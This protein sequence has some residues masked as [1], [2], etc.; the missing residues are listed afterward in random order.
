MYRTEAPTTCCTTLR[1]RHQLQPNLSAATTMSQLGKEKWI[2]LN[3]KKKKEKRISH[4]ISWYHR[5]VGKVA[6]FIA[7]IRQELTW[8]TIYVMLCSSCKNMLRHEV[9]GRC[10]SMYLVACRARKVMY[11][12][13][14]LWRHCPQYYQSMDEVKV[15]NRRWGPLL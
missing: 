8:S 11:L 5:R 3:L 9:L 14:L 1:F 12:S 10:R 7:A 6:R 2:N 13:A 15:L 4:V